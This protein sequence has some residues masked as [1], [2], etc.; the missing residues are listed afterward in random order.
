MASSWIHTGVK[1][2]SRDFCL[3]YLKNIEKTLKE[4]FGMKN[5]IELFFWNTLQMYFF[6]CRAVLAFAARTNSASEVKNLSLNWTQKANCMVMF[7][8]KGNFHLSE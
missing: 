7:Y 4:N 5:K 3:H 2:I 1:R 8:V 6:Y